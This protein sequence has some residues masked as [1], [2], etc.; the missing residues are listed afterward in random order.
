MLKN[1]RYIREFTDLM[2]EGFIFI[3]EEGKIRIYNKKAKEIFGIRHEGGIGHKKGRIH[4]GD[5]VIIADNALGKDDGGLSCKDL[6][7]IGIYDEKIGYKGAFIGIGVYGKKIRPIYKYEKNAKDIL[8]VD[9]HFQNVNIRVQINFMKKFMDITVKDKNFQLSY[10]HSMGHM[11]VL[12]QDTKEV[13]FY[14]KEGYTARKESIKDLLLGKEFREKGEDAKELDVIGKD[15][16]EIHEGGDTI[17]EFYKASKG[18]DIHYKDKFTQINGFPTLCT[19]VPI[20]VQ[21]KRV[22]AALKVED[23]SALK[24]L[25]KERDEALLS[26][27]HMEMKMREEKDSQD[28][29]ADI[30]GESEVINNVKKLA[31]KASKSNSTV[32]LLGESGTGK[33][34]LAKAIHEASKYK[35]KPFVHVNCASIPKDLLESELFGYEKGAF[36]GAC[37]KGKQGLFEVASGG[38]IFL[39]EIGE[40]ESFIQVKLLKVLQ[41]KTFYR[42]GGTVEKTANVRI[43][44]ATNKNLEE[45]MIKGRFRE[46]LYYR[47]NVFPIWLPPLQERKQ[48]IYFLVQAILP[49]ICRRMECEEKII[50]GEVL[51]RLMEYEWPGNIRELENVLERAVNI[52]EGNIIDVSHL[53][54]NVLNHKNE[55]TKHIKPLKDYIQQAEKDAIIKALK[56]YDYD[57]N[58]AMRALK[59]GKTS[60]YEKL[61]KYGIRSFRKT[62]NGSQI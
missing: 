22:G 30:L 53:Y 40:I 60:F 17:K 41:N 56:Y 36:T 45:E 54:L 46:D 27:Q 47:I 35:D 1:E 5:I 23:I 49:K 32:L 10:I 31:Y 20:T 18:I 42:V 29:F 6:E 25:I 33:T 61:K 34:L 28:L 11:V 15:I 26:I 50:S 37:T 8:S 55:N 16:F 7:K 62:E 24:K 57:R 4:I 12:D 43:I 52:A 2:S 58:E 13:K 38:T 3:D 44:A 39:D 59:I 51:Y 21:N 14:Q 9:T 48:D 19:L